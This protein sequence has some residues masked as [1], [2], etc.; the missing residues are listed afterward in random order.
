MVGRFA[1]WLATT[2]IGLSDIDF[3]TKDWFDTCF[4]SRYIKIN[5]AVH[6]PVVSYSKAVHT[7][8]FGSGNKLGDTAHAIEQAI[9]SMDVEMS[10]ITWHQL[11]YNICAESPKRSISDC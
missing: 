8:L 7:Q 3:A 2:A 10:K 11:D 9:L 1:G 5:D 4:L 6:G